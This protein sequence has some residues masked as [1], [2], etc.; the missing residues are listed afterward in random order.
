MGLERMKMWII[1]IKK[2]PTKPSPPKLSMFWSTPWPGPEQNY[3]NGLGVG[4]PKKGKNRKKKAK[5]G[6]LY[7][8]PSVCANCGAQIQYDKTSSGEDWAYCRCDEPPVPVTE[9]DDRIAP[10]EFGYEPNW[11]FARRIHY[12]GQDIRVFPHEF[13]KLKAENMRLYITGDD[14]SG[15][16]HELV[17]EGVAAEREINAILDGETRPIY[18]TA[19]NEG[20]TPAQA[21][22]VA[23]GQDITLENDEFPPAI[24]WYRPLRWAAEPFCEEW[25]M[26]ED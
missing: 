16:S 18:E 12:K 24:G 23:M 22:L 3:G 6:D 11:A 4:A 8:I 21:M 5:D 13:N 14:E 19:M 1:L 17:P 25:E 15:P 20:A 2:L 26:Q 9:D 7:A 10:N